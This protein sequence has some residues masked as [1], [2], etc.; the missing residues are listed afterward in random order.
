MA[1]ED[2]HDTERI[3]GS[4]LHNPP[5]NK[6]N[7][8]NMRVT[9]EVNKSISIDERNRDR[10][11]RFHTPEYTAKQTGRPNSSNY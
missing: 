4:Q 6:N 1:T 10:Q 8:K 5:D 7:K 9:N 3:N 2:I 11:P